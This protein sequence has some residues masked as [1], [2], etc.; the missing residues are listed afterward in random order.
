M[1]HAVKIVI[2]GRWYR[3]NNITET[4]KGSTMDFDL[5]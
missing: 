3:L 5:K 2:E 1:E 4:T